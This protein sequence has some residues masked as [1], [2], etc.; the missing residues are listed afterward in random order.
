[1]ERLREPSSEVRDVVE[2][3]DIP[4]FEKARSKYYE[5]RRNYPGYGS[6]TSGHLC[7][8][9]CCLSLCAMISLNRHQQQARHCLRSYPV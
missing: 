2:I 6:K 1:M 9:N 4:S 8:H 3:R 7:L 5:G